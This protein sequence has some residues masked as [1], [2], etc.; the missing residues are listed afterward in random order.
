MKAARAIVRVFMELKGAAAGRG[1]DLNWE[2]QID[3]SIE[4]LG[5]WLFAFRP[6][7]LPFLVPALKAQRP[8]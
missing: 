3:Q 4:W 2:I 8:L 6:E 7:P 5:C 1:A